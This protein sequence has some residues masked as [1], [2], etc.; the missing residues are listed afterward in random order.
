MSNSLV[1]VDSDDDN[2][3]EAGVALVG[4]YLL[5]KSTY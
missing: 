5:M 4:I 2:I 1:V 3:V